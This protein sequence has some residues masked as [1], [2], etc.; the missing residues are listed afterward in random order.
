MPA[1]PSRKEL[2][3]EHAPSLPVLNVDIV[4][5]T[6]KKE[7]G[8]H[9]EKIDLRFALG[10]T[11]VIFYQI[12]FLESSLSHRFRTIRCD[13]HALV[14]IGRISVFFSSLTKII[15]WIYGE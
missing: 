8:E 12:L 11:S 13:F 6:A 15:K 9:E 14:S 7:N 2:R 1:T 3:K 4:A 10:V 5:S